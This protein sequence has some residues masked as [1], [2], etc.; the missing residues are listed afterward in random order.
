MRSLGNENMVYHQYLC[1]HITLLFHPK[2]KVGKK[3]TYGVVYEFLYNNR[4]LK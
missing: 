3:N 2:D 1:D 4:E